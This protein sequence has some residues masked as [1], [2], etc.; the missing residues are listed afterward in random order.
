MP[1]RKKQHKVSRTDSQD[2]TLTQDDIVSIENACKE[3][4]KH[5]NGL[6]KLIREASALPRVAIPVR[7]TAVYRVLF[8]GV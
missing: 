3:S 1:S 7:V 5:L 8:I 6:L 2:S 4:L